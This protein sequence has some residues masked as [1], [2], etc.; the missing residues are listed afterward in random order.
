MDSTHVNAKGAP[1]MK[2]APIQENAVK[3]AIFRF[4][5]PDQSQ[6]FDAETVSWI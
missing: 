6:P 5:Q 3:T 2:T 4:G 1:R